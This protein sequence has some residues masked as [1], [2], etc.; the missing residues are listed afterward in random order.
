MP[1][2][3]RLRTVPEDEA[4]EVRELLS[5]HDLIFRETSGGFLGLGTAAIWID[6]DAQ[7]AKAQSLLSG[8]QQNRFEQARSQYHED[9]RSGN[10]E[11]LWH[12]FKRQPT[13]FVVYILIALLIIYFST[14]PFFGLT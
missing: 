5:S 14:K 4:N 1:L 13:Q 8:Y 3:F 12:S 7:F 6:G 10:N 9:K 11:T 2:L